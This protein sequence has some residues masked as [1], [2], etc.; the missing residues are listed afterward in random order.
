MKAS[1]G[2][3]ATAEAVAKKFGVAR[4]DPRDGREMAQGRH[5]HHLSSS[6]C[7]TRPNISPAT[8]PGAISAPGGQLV[9]AT[10]IYA[11]VLG[12]RVVVSDD[13]EARALMTASWL[14]QM[15]WKDVYVLPQA[16]S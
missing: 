15:G 5:A 8:L 10:D 1:P 7:A 2:P 3:R 14:K 9:Q 4:T 6:T 13:K 11:G 16:G 12:A